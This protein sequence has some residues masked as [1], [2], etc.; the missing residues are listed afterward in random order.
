VALFVSTM[1]V[2]Q[3]DASSLVQSP[4]LSHVSFRFV[5]LQ[6]FFRFVL[7]CSSMVVGVRFARRSVRDASGLG[8]VALVV[9]VVVVVG[10]LLLGFL[11]SF[12][13]N[14]WLDDIVLEST[15]QGLLRE[16]FQLASEVVFFLFQGLEEG[17]HRRAFRLNG[18]DVVVFDVVVVFVVVVVVADFAA[19]VGSGS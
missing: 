2:K 18:L 9:V 5:S 6:L 4:T 16:D 12:L 8:V 19:V 15:K 14:R 3:T 10:P 17:N 7:I 13:W 11:D 1:S